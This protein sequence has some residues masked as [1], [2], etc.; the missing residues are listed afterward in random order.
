MEIIINTSP[1]N[2]NISVIEVEGRMDALSVGEFEEKVIPQCSVDGITGYVIDFSKLIYISSAVLRAI[3][4][5]AK[6][7]KEQGRKIAICNLSPEVHEVFKISGFD[8]IITVCENLDSA[9]SAVA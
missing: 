3:L 1:D 7:C 4:K 2:G 5:V 8:L 6:L 9:K